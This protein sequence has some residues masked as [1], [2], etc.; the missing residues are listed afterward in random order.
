ML[1]II[2]KGKRDKK[3]LQEGNIVLPP[4]SLTAFYNSLRK[5]LMPLEAYYLRLKEIDQKYNKE[6]T[7]G[8]DTQNAMEF[9]NLYGSEW[10]EFMR[11]AEKLG[12]KYREKSI[13]SETLL[14]FREVIKWAKETNSSSDYLRVIDSSVKSFGYLIEDIEEAKLKL[15]SDDY[16]WEGWLETEEE[17]LEDG[18]PFPTKSERDLIYNYNNILSRYIPLVQDP[19]N[20]LR[21]IGE[22][23][24][25]LYGDKNWMPPEIEEVETLYHASIDA[26]PLSKTGF[27]AEVPDTA[28]IG[29]SQSDKSGRP[30]ISFTSDLYVAN[31]VARAL[32]EAV[33]IAKGKIT[34]ANILDWSSREGIK[35]KVVDAYRTSYGEFKKTNSA[36]NTFNLY[37]MY[38]AF[39]KRYDPLFF[40]ITTP[41][42]KKWANTRD[43]DIGVVEAKVDMTN[44]D[45]S[46]LSNMQEYRVPPESVISITRVIK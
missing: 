46:Y 7:V 28:G 19:M 17:Y 6:Y 5:K 22:Q 36:I 9:F 35:S 38:L 15:Y 24:R 21:R 30:A 43:S 2:V 39:S 37:R 12:P 16:A 13:I 34:F 14:G 40:N 18:V 11:A 27:S 33:M 31:Q 4:R 20:R 29:G 3:F 23:A 42:L 45:I 25:G 8:R 41:V 44:P 1:T 32:K 26:V 10:E